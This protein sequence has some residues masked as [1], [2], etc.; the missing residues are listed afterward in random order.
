MSKSHKWA[1]VRGHPSIP[2]QYNS[3][4]PLGEVNASCPFS[5]S[6]HA[7][8]HICNEESS[9]MTT[10]PGGSEAPN[11]K[12]RRYHFL[13][14]WFPQCLATT[15]HRYMAQRL[16]HQE[17]EGKLPRNELLVLKV[18]PIGP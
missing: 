1:L 6:N 16:C 17:P 9:G 5:L 2:H 12:S 11:S 15:R 13:E 8:G 14:F 7:C 4:E 18:A 10:W 3:Q